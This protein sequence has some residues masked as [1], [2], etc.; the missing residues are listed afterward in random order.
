VYKWFRHFKQGQQSLEECPQRNGRLQCTRGPLRQLQMNEW[1]SWDVSHSLSHVTVHDHLNIH[2]IW[3]P[4]TVQTHGGFAWQPRLITNK[5]NDKTCSCPGTVSMV[6]FT[7]KC[8]ATSYIHTPNI[9]PHS[10]NCPHQNSII[11]GGYRER[12]A[13]VLPVAMITRERCY[14]K[15]GVQ[16]YQPSWQKLMWIEVRSLYTTTYS[17]H[18]SKVLF[19]QGNISLLILVTLTTELFQL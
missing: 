10:W 18:N 9:K 15:Y 16:E 4:C 2:D 7:V 13:S 5:M 17:I 14:F 3:P 19:K 11:Q 1:Q 12:P 8:G 6:L